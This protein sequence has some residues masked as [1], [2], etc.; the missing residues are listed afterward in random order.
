MFVY[1]SFNKQVLEGLWESMMALCLPSSHTMAFYFVVNRG[2]LF[3]DHVNSSAENSWGD[4]MWI[5][6]AQRHCTL[7]T[8]AKHVR[9]G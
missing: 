9:I 5:S 7:V 8:H 3:A 6:F 4:S 1:V 2:E